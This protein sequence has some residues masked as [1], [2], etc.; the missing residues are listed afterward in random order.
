MTNSA[1]KTLR[2]T[3]NAAMNPIRARVMIGKVIKRFADPK[4]TIDSEANRQWL[5]QNARPLEEY[6]AGFDA[7]LV[8]ETQDFMS[9]LKNRSAQILSQIPHDLGGGAGVPL[10]YALVRK[11]APQ[12]VVETGVAAGFS[13]ATILAAMAKNGI[14]HLYSSD[15][16]YFRLEN[17]EQYVG[18]VVDRALKSRWSL[19]LRGD[20]NNLPEI[21]KA[22]TGKVDIFHYDSDKS[23]IGREYAMKTMAPH[24]ADDGLIIMD[25]I[26]DNAYF[27]DYVA[28][29]PA[30]QW[31]VFAYE[32]KYIGIIGRS[33]K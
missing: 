6:L 7:A 4:G 11:R 14:G 28:K 25:D 2:H 31:T 32:G 33:L 9:D 22:I 30:L 10:L 18:V 17:P 19:Y 24:M 12:V 1:M 21:T 27:H 20:E 8:T 5:A 16:P 3:L 26:Q 15:F 13:S 23:Y 29:H